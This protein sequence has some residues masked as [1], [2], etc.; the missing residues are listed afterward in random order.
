MEY[1]KKLPIWLR[2]TASISLILVVSF[3]SMVAWLTSE[4]RNTATAQAR[5][6]AGSVHQMTLAGLTG[7]MITGTIDQRDIFLG[8]IKQMEGVRDLAVIRSPAVVQQ[9]GPGKASEQTADSFESAAQN[10]SRTL[11]RTHVDAAGE[12]R[13]FVI[14]IVASTNSLGKNCL[15]CHQVSEG[16]VLG[17]VSMKLSLARMNASIDS[18]QIKITGAALALLSVL[19]VLI[20]LLIRHFVTLPVEAMTQR[21]DEIAKGEG[22]LSHRLPIEKQD[23]VGRASAAFNRM[24]N[25]FSTLVGRIGGTAAQVK[26]SVNNLEL[27]AN[28][29]ASRSLEQQEKSAIAT[30]A[31]DAVARGVASIAAVSAQVRTQSHTTLEASA[32]GQKNLETLVTSMKHV[33]DSVNRIAATVQNFVSSTQSIKTMTGQVKDIADQTNLLALNAAIEAARAGESGRGFAVVADEVRKLAEKSSSSANEIDTVTHLIGSQSTQVLQA[34]EEGLRQLRLSRADVGAVG[35]ILE[36]T[37]GG[38]AD[39][40]RGVDQISE[41]TAEQQQASQEALSNIV[42]IA[43]MAKINNGAVN[44]VVDASRHLNELAYGMSEA[45]DRFHVERT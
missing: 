12:Y 37:A 42:M 28:E 32:R 34:I 22:D 40:N 13:Q 9:F 24:M 33:E 25:S 16:T 21:L 43:E 18:Q 4:Y 17:A 26:Q 8:Q 15:T 36:Q 30:E 38:I 3:A 44:F 45:V 14:P 23:E 11:E 29:V 35:E 41:A 31:V 10:L 5:D 19:V 27:A 2:L 39:V 20:Y 7:M 6:F 1:K